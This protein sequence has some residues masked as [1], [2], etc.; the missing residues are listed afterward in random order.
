M[1]YIVLYLICA[2]LEVQHVIIHTRQTHMVICVMDIFVVNVALSKN[3]H[4]K[5]QKWVG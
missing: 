5:G 1:V 4:G 3:R 2:L